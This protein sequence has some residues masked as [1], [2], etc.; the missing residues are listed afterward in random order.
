MR[1]TALFVL[2]AVLAT[3]MP[4][5]SSELGVAMRRN[6]SMVDGMFRG[7]SADL[8]RN[9]RGTG[10]ATE[11]SHC[12]GVVVDSWGR[13]V[14]RNNFAVYAHRSY[15]YPGLRWSGGYGYD[16]YGRRF[17]RNNDGTWGLAN[18]AAT[19]II[20]G[21]ELHKINKIQHQIEHRPAEQA[22][23]KVTEAPTPSSV[24][25][26][27]KSGE[28]LS[29][30][31][32][33]LATGDGRE[34]QNFDGVLHVA[35]LHGSPCKVQAHRIGGVIVLATLASGCSKSPETDAAKRRVAALKDGQKAIQITQHSFG[36]R[37]NC[38]NAMRRPF[39]S[40][41]GE[42]VV[43]TYRRDDG[44]LQC[45]SSSGFD[46]VT[47]NQLS[48]IT[49]DEVAEIRSDKNLYQKPLKVP[50]CPSVDCPAPPAPPTGP[51]W[52]PEQTLTP[53]PPPR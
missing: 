39:N 2:M 29:V 26:L 49:E 6:S 42:A 30:F 17:S 34:V 40:D 37:V 15:S 13:Q 23:Q 4:A 41:T 10:D 25:L 5:M 51:Q 35:P 18:L 44:G 53:I 32:R 21:I 19:A 24:I 48:E 12:Y 28:C 8:C 16:S 31:G 50:D 9:H 20:G 11:L 43:W 45:Y 33:D 38:A 7:L 52:G 3:A 14:D 36:V 46:Q 1:K 47:G 27:N 22:N